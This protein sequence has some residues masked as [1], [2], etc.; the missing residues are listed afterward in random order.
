M[1]GIHNLQL[2]GNSP[3]L[4]TRPQGQLQPPLLTS[5]VGHYQGSLPDLPQQQ[6]QKPA[7]PAVEPMSTPPT[8]RNNRSSQIR[9]SV[10]KPSSPF[11]SS[12]SIVPGR[13]LLTQPLSRPGTPGAFATKGVFEATAAAP[14][15]NADIWSTPTAGQSS[16]QEEE[17]RTP[18]TLTQDE[19]NTMMQSGSAELPVSSKKPSG[20]K[21]FRP[22]VKKQ[23]LGADL[24]G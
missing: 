17:F 5:A 1:K 9:Q 13:G 22:A 4:V 21:G 6:Q 8:N 20:R 19:W 12:A 3:A 2:Q 23:R 14:S 16:R 15:P 18:G 24:T 10:R 11:G 7:E